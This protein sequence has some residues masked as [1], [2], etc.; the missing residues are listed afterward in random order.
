MDEIKKLVKQY[1]HCID[2]SEKIDIKDKLN[3]L[4]DNLYKGAYIRSKIHILNNN[5]NSSTFYHNKE[6]K[7]GNNKIIHHI[8]DGGVDKKSTDDILN[9]FK[10][11]YKEL[12]TEEQVDASF[13][14]KCFNNL[15]QVSNNDNNMLNSPLSLDEIKLALKD[16]DHTKSPGS[17]GLTSFIYIKFF[18]LFGNILLQLYNTCFDLGH[19]SE[20]QKLSYITLLCKDPNNKTSV[21]NYRPISLLNIDRKFLSKLLANRL[22]KV[23]DSIIGISQTCSVPGRTIFDNVH[24]IRN[25]IDYVEQKNINACFICLDQEKAFDRVSWSYLYHTLVSF[26]FSDTFIT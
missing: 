10:T 24:L 18:H 12:Y 14:D 8:I 7:N 13:N 21:K 2:I 9:S 6:F 26:A 11:F 19:M 15:P 22:G 5:E 4:Q 23:L 1:K 17:D 25:I 20:S 16:M 3:K